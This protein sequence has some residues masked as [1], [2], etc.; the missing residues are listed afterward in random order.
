MEGISYTGCIIFTGVK[1][2]ANAATE[3]NTDS[4]R[5]LHEHHDPHSQTAEEKGQRELIKTRHL[6][7]IW[8]LKKKYFSYLL[9]AY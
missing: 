9:N 1:Q 5:V 7:G 3:S 8:G 6:L 2:V 4:A